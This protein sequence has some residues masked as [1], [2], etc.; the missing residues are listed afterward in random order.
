M[1]LNINFFHQNELNDFVTVLRLLIIIVNVD[2]LVHTVVSS[3]TLM[4]HILSWTC[5]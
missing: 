4:L 1:L 2:Y 5:A 3:Y